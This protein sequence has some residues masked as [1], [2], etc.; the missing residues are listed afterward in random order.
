MKNEG[1]GPQISITSNRKKIYL[2]KFHSGFRQCRYGPK[3]WRHCRRLRQEQHCFHGKFHSGK[4]RGM[5]EHLGEDKPT[6]GSS[7]LCPNIS[8]VRNFKNSSSLENWIGNCL[9]WSTKVSELDINVLIVAI[10]IDNY[11][12]NFT[13]LVT[14][15]EFLF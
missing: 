6:S 7:F 4:R 12:E 10:M 2:N 15:K 9:T 14:K 1:G 3:A 13:S 8:S 11:G 5:S